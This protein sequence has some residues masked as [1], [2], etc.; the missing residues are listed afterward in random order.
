MGVILEYAK[1]R[2]EE[3]KSQIREFSRNPID[4]ILKVQPL[5]RALLIEY[6]DA[7]RPVVGTRWEHRVAGK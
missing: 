4:Y 7:V 5:R 1:G 3:I 2:I 6:L